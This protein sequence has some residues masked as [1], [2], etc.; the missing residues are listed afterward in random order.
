VAAGWDRVVL[1]VWGLG[2]GLRRNS[3]VTAGWDR[4][5]AVLSCCGCVD[6][7]LGWEQKVDI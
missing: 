4:E 6:T 2:K 5:R 3:G 7:G 1:W